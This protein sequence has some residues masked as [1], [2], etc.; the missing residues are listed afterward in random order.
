MHAC[1]V[2]RTHPLHH[3]RDQQRQRTAG[4]PDHHLGCRDDPR[5]PRRRWRGDDQRRRSRHTAMALLAGAD[6]Q[7]VLHAGAGAAAAG[8]EPFDR[9]DGRHGPAA[10]RRQSWLPQLR[11]ARRAL[12]RRSLRRGRNAARRGEDGAGGLRSWWRLHLRHQDHQ[13]RFASLQ[14]RCGAE[15]QHV[16]GWRRRIRGTDHGHRAAPWLHA[17]PRCRAV[18]VHGAARTSRRRVANVRHHRD[19][20]AWASTRVLGAQL[21]RRVRA[22]RRAARAAAGNAGAEQRELRLGACWCA[23]AAQQPAS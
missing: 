16:H 10:G 9:C 4:G 11:R 5:R 14:R 19:H 3:Y 17:R 21:L 8:G 23:A 15:R 6:G 18:L 13:H 1:P 12:V 22:W 7:S 2:R 20:A